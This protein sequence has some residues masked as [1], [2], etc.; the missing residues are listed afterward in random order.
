M[1]LSPRASA[2]PI[3]QRQRALVPGHPAAEVD[4][5]E[6]PPAERQGFEILPR[7]VGRAVIHRDHPGQI[8]AVADQAVDTH[9]G[10][11]DLV[12][13]GKGDGVVGFGHGK[14]VRS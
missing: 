11:M 12:V 13:A 1:I 3:R 9:A 4:L 10:V 8:D 14:S 6:D 7:L 5:V 2:V